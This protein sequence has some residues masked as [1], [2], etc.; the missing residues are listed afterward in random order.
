M[1]IFFVNPDDVPGIEEP[2]FSLLDEISY[3][4]HQFAVMGGDRCYVVRIQVDGV[5]NRINAT[6]IPAWL[7]SINGN[8]GINW[9]FVNKKSMVWVQMRFQYSTKV[10][11]NI[12]LL[13]L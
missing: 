4:F 12:V 11:L 10:L 3:G 1:V 7:R 6:Y 5:T 2:L 8:I 9:F 13:G